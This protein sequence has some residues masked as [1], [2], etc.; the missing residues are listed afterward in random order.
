MIEKAL[1]YLHSL[2]RPAHLE[3]GQN[4]RVFLLNED[5]GYSPVLAPKPDHLRLAT[6]TSLVDALVVNRDAL[7]LEEV[8]VHVEDPETVSVYS[9]VSGPERER[10]VLYRVHA[11]LP[12]LV[13]DHFQEL[14][15]FRIGLMAGFMDREERDD[16]LAMTAGVKNESSGTIKDNGVSQSL[17]VKVGASTLETKRTKGSYKLAPYRTFLEVEQPASAFVFRIR[18]DHGF[19][20]G[21]FTADGGAW[22]L[23]AMEN[24]G[25]WLRNALKNALVSNEPGV[26]VTVPVL[27]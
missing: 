25:A 7:N 14:E 1:R 18:E 15:T 2:A 11:K 12:D 6:L 4:G 23:T 24:V 19:T 5:G 21:L 3:I 9:K 16:I 26:S 17:D 13:L 20:A 27:V 8:Y 10:E 22:R